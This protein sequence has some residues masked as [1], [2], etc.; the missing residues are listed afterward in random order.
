VAIGHLDLNYVGYA[1]IA[2]FVVTW[3]IAFA[4]WRVAKIEERWTTDLQ[5]PAAE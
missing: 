2:L 1:I 3:L 5:S 4:V